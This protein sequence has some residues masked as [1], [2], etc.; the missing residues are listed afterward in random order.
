MA[1]CQTGIRLQRH[2]EAVGRREHHPLQRLQS[3]EADNPYIDNDS[4]ITRGMTSF[5]HWKSLRP[6]FRRRGASSITGAGTGLTTATTP[7]KSPRSRTS[8][9][10]TGCWAYRGIKSA[11]LFT[12]NR[13]TVGFDYQHF[14]GESWNKLSPSTRQNPDSRLVTASPAWTSRW[15]NLQAMWIS[16]RTSTVGFHWTPVSA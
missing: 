15:M 16:G 12:G 5:D 1:L 3:R 4:R 7:E 8:T 6:Y 9:P 13:L 11:T 10:R 14:G 2:L